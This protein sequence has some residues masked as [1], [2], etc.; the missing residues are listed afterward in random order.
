MP[1]VSHCLERVFRF[2]S[3][4]FVKRKSCWTECGEMGCLLENIDS[5]LL[6]RIFSFGVSIWTFS[7][8]ILASFTFTVTLLS[9]HFYFFDSFG[10]ILFLSLRFS[11]TTQLSQLDQDVIF[12]Y[13]L[14]NSLDIGDLVLKETFWSHF[15]CVLLGRKIPEYSFGKTVGR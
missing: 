12:V 2:H 5:L 6:V 11:C 1:P 3:S 9:F 10:F 8:F 4:K 7:F 13:S 15:L 14:T